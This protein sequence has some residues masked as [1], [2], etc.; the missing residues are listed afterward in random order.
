MTCKWWLTT[1]IILI[2]NRD[3]LQLSD[4]ELDKSFNSCTVLLYHELSDYKNESSMGWHC[5]SKYSLDGK[6]I[7]KMN[8]QVYNTAL[9]IFL[10]G[11]GSLL[12]WRK[13]FEW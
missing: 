2:A 4:V 10:I 13:K 6:F 5:D 9:V 8:G 7:D 11:S 3:E 1:L 12:K